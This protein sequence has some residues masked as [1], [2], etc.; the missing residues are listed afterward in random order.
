M[1]P[2]FQ[3]EFY[4][5]LGGGGGEWGGGLQKTTNKFKSCHDP[6]TFYQKQSNIACRVNCRV[7][8]SKSTKIECPELRLKVQF[9]IS[10]PVEW[11]VSF[12]GESKRVALDAEIGR[13]LALLLV[14]VQQLVRVHRRHRRL[15]NNNR[16]Y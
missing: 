15:G 14:L 4:N 11:M 7:R 13:Q 3:I 16:T 5:I 8:Y 1:V 10:H 9:P 6:K 12:A 2:S